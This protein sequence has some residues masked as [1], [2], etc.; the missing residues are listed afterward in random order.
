M[1]RCRRAGLGAVDVEFQQ[2]CHGPR[3]PEVGA[4]ENLR[5]RS[6]SEARRR[7]SVRSFVARWP[8]CAYAAVRRRGRRPHLSCAARR[9][10]H[11]AERAAVV[12]KP[13]DG[14][15]LS[16]TA[17]ANKP[18]NP[19]STMKLVTTYSALH[20]LGPAFT[21]RTEVLSEAP[22][23]GEVLRGDLYVRGGG[24][25]QAG[26]RRPVAAGQP[27]ARLRH[28]RNPRRRGAR[29]DVL[30][31]ARA[32]PGGIRRRGRPRLQRRARSRCS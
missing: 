24:D 3:R 6:S 26:H 12:V 4:G 31:A 16:W 8:G 25:P 15:A 28:P 9:G 22:L 18:M 13:L 10:A 5:P 29:Q 21:F 32:R 19:A 2:R 1:R 14:G 30:R 11:P 7:A 20:L 23:I 17:N 27:A